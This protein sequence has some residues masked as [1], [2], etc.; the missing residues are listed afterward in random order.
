MRYFVFK[1]LRVSL[2]SRVQCHF[3]F[4]SNYGS[5]RDSS[6]NKKFH[7]LPRFLLS[8]KVVIFSVLEYLNDTNVAKR[9]VFIKLSNNLNAII[10]LLISVFAFTFFHS[11]LKKFQSI[12]EPFR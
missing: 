9:F 1:I 5:T 8:F 10:T 2:Q 6:L 12:F 3:V 11:I 4:V 7:S